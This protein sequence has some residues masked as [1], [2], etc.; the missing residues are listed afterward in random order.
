MLHPHVYCCSTL[1]VSLELVYT[2]ASRF[3]RSANFSYQAIFENAVSLR[4][5]SQRYSCAVPDSLGR[6]FSS[7]I[8]EVQRLA[9]EAQREVLKAARYGSTPTSGM[10][11]EG[12]IIELLTRAIV[13]ERFTDALRGKLEGS[14]L[15]ELKEVLFETAYPTPPP[16]WR[17]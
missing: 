14:K 8:A 10:F 9:K 6:L 5:W 15:G 16:N 11:N 1:Q 12:D 4:I 7:G 3:S 13:R 2:V 17:P